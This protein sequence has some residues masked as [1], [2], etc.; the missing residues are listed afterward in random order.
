[1]GKGNQNTPLK[2]KNSKNTPA[3]SKTDIKQRVIALLTREGVSGNDIAQ[4]LGIHHVTVSKYKNKVKKV[5][6]Y[7]LFKPSELKRASKQTV[8]IATGAPMVEVCHR[9]VLVY[10][11]HTNKPLLVPATLD[12][13]IKAQAIM[14]T[15]EVPKKQIVE[16]TGTVAHAI[17]PLDEF[18]PDQGAN[19]ID[20]QPKVE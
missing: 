15:T 16:H 13:Q 1:M 19:I 14:Y 17:I 3:L 8:K 12:Q 11:P 4:A 10:D 20:V 9:G 6:N 5:K 7:L 2:A 18:R